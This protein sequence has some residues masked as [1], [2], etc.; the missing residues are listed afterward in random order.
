[1]SS[2]TIIGVGSFSTVTVLTQQ[3]PN[4]HRI[5]VK[6]IED[7]LLPTTTTT[8]LHQLLRE[9]I[10]LRRFGHPNLVAALSVAPHSNGIHIQMLASDCDLFAL[11]K[12]P[13]TAA[14]LTHAHIQFIQYQI[15]SG[16][17]YLHANDVIHRDL[18]PRN[19]FVNHNGAVQIGDFGLCC[20]CASKRRSRR[21]GDR[22]GGGGGGQQKTST[23]AADDDDTEDALRWRMLRVSNIAS[24]PYTAPEILLDKKKC[25]KASDVWSAG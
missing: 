17:R 22:G 18:N 16:L 9:L 21:G 10:V 4:R 11:M 25:S 5:A 2:S 1:M 20:V 3:P 7:C 6:A 14:L 19:I 15:L 8:Q 23:V 24:T 13:R 12:T